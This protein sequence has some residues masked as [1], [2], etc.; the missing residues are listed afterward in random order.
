MTS[1]VGA[2]LSIVTGK[3]GYSQSGRKAQRTM[4]LTLAGTGVQHI[5]TKLAMALTLA[6]TGVLGKPGAASPGLSLVLAGS[7]TVVSNV[8]LTRVQHAAN[9]NSSSNASVSQAYPSNVTAGDLLVVMGGSEF[10]S[11]ITVSD[12]LSN[13]WIQASTVTSSGYIQTV[14]YANANASG[15]CT[16]TITNQ[17]GSGSFTLCDVGQY[18]SSLS[19]GSWHLDQV[20]QGLGTG[21]AQAS[22]PVTTIQ[23][24]EV[25]IGW[26]TCAIASGLTSGSGWNQLESA[27]TYSVYQDQI[28]TS[29]GTF[30]STSS[31][32]SGTWGANIATFYHA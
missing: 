25:L 17:G 16:V 24:P 15:A 14:W 3:T 22:G 26:N 5:P 11:G 4:S 20:N 19:S 28:V 6:G 12:T 31:S 2:G 23:Y 27:S 1:Y 13:A 32:A 21:G 10:T 9:F 18:H 7:G 29:T 30:N 8:V